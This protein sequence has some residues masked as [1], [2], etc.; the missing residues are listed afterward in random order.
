MTANAVSLEKRLRKRC[1]GHRLLW[2]FLR[3]DR[4]TALHGTQPCNANAQS[5]PHNGD[6]AISIVR[7]ASSKALRTEPHQVAGP[8]YALVA[9]ML[10]RAALR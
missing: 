3:T 2:K 5:L 9:K 8:S 4:T 10:D 6:K 1:I 7:Y